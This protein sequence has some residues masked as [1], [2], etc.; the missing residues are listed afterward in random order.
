MTIISLATRDQSLYEVQDVIVAS[1]DQ[2][3]VTLHV[4]FSNEWNSFGKSAV[5]FTEKMSADVYEIVLDTNGECLVPSEVLVESGYLFIGVR[6]VNADTGAVKTSTL[7]K[8]R[9]EKGAPSG[10]TTAVE[11]TPDIYQQLLT[12]YGTTNARF[13]NLIALGEGSTTGDA[14]LTDIRVDVN[15]NVLETAGTS[16]REQIK[17]VRR[18][19]T[20]VAESALAVT[21]VAEPGQMIVVKSVDDNGVTLTWEAVH[22][23]HWKEVI[24]SDK[25]ILDTT[26]N[27]T[28]SMM[29]VTGIGT[30]NIVEGGEYVVTWNGTEYN[31]TA[32]IRDMSLMLG[33]FAV[34]GG[35]TDTGEPFNIEMTTANTAIVSKATSDAEAIT[36]KVN[37]KE[38]IIYHKLDKEYLPDDIGINEVVVIPECVPNFENN[39]GQYMYI[40]PAE[41]N[42]APSQ[43]YVLVWVEHQQENHS[44]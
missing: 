10:N 8:K 24:S 35:D 5:F 25:A 32:Y 34:I 28:T 15:G 14:E 44:A 33:N 4:K 43:K 20:A 41:K 42:I 17:Q 11:I 38:K 31:C 1:G 7:I 18:E 19:I 36:L 37:G 16:V 27:F 26:V 13:D 29:S 39:D 40:I 21:N 30:G 2:K 9:L 22:R 3:S 23:T 6:G 12:A